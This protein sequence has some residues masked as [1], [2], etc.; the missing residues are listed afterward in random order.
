VSGRCAWCPHG[1]MSTGHS[2]RRSTRWLK[3]SGRHRTRFVSEL[4]VLRSI[5]GLRHES[6]SSELA[7]TWQLKRKYA[8]LRRVNDILEGGVGL[9]REATRPLVE[10]LIVIIDANREYRRG[11]LRW[12]SRGDL[13]GAADR[14]PRPTTRRGRGRRRP[15]ARSTSCRSSLP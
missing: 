14:L 10:V 1:R 7:E 5:G 13:R 9:L 4:A 6:T 3:C 11:V 8:A 2:W 15:D 12:G